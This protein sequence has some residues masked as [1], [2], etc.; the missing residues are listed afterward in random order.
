MKLARGLTTVLLLGVAAAAM[1]GPEQVSASGSHVKMTRELAQIN[2]SMKARTNPSSGS[3]PIQTLYSRR[4]ITR[5]RTVLPVVAHAT[6]RH[7]APW[8]RVL[9]PG[10]P[11]SRTGWIPGR[12]TTRSST[13]WQVVV[14]TY[15]RRVIAYF[16]GRLMGSFKA[17]VGKPSTPTP[18]GR[19]FVEETVKLSRSEAGAPYALALSARSNVLQ[20]FAGGPGQIALHGTDNIGGALGTAVSHGCVRLDTRAISWLATRI[21]PGFPVNIIR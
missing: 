8:L 9:L 14:H 2:T 10:R 7:G 21:G 15:T 18:L 6:D 16:N 12:L 17:V 1:A 13:H 5:A 20:E 19:S 11:N 4:P 3:K